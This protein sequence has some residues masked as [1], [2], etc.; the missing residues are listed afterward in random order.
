M[1]INLKWWNTKYTHNQLINILQKLSK[2][3]I[4]KISWNSLTQSKAI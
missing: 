4:D 2:A 3:I 1:I